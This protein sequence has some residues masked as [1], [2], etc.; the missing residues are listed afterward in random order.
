MAQRNVLMVVTSHDRIAPDHPTGIWLSEFTEPYDLF[1]AAGYNIAVASVRGGAAPVDPRSLPAEG[2]APPG[3]RAA[4]E[5]TLPL[6][7]VDVAAYDAVFLPGGHGTMYDLPESEELAHLLA[8]FYETSRIIAAV[9]YGPAGLIGAR[10]SDGSPLVRGKRL[11]AFTNEEEKETG[12]DRFMPFLLEDRLR[13]LGAAF[14][15][16]PKWSD[17]VERDG[18]LITG[19]NPQSSKSAAQAIIEALS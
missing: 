16:A 10:L 5:K 14:V 19:Q 4:L 6:R 11:T 1:R 18:F 9:C 8:F 7:D 2:S 15:P 17:H 3:V 12:L 13:S